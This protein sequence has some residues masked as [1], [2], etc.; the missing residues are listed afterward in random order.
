MEVEGKVDA[1]VN[2]AVPQSGHHGM[3]SKQLEMGMRFLREVISAHRHLLG[4]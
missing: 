3:P 2:M 4:L 1:E